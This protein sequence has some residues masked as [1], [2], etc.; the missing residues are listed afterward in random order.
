MPGTSPALAQPDPAP[1]TRRTPL[2]QRSAST[3][4]QILAAASELLATTDVDELTTSLVAKQAGISVGG[5]YRFFPDKQS[6][7]DAIAAR[8]MEEFQTALARLA[9][10]LAL[11]N[12]PAFL[13]RIIDAYVE[14]LDARPDFRAIALGRHVSAQARVAH[15]A[16]DSGP[17]ALVRWFLRKRL[18]LKSGAELDLKLRVLIETGERL[19][20]YAYT[21]PTASERKRVLAEMKRMLGN[22]LFASN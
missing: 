3:V 7:L 21:Q 13:E 9:A 20:A 2:Q 14:F 8:H 22:Y 15:G 16:P 19:I 11:A 17:A 10:R 1:A 5:L 18:G 12:G 4:Q 6:I